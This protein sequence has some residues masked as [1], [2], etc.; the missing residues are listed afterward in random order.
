[1]QLVGCELAHDALIVEL[2][3]LGRPCPSDTRE[4]YLS[5]ERVTACLDFGR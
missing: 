4:T 1:M 3:P 5:N 2:A